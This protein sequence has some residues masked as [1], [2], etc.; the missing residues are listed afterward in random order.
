MNRP[1]RGERE[2]AATTRY[3]G[4]FF[5]P[6]RIRRSFTA[7]CVRP[8]VSR[9]TARVQ[10]TMM[11]PVGGSAQA[12]QGE[13]LLRRGVRRGG[14]TARTAALLGLLALAAAALLGAGEAGDAL[15]H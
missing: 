15:H 9:G 14:R 7:T 3:V 4:C 8:Y 10:R 12:R 2:S 1:L 13:G 11:V 5:L 6:I